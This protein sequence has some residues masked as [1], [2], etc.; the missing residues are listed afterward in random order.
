MNKISFLT[1]VILLGGSLLFAQ[2]IP[3]SLR[4]CLQ[5]AVDENI[6]IKT[7]RLE[8]EKSLF[9][10]A[11]AIAALVP[12]I[13]IGANYQDN[14]SLPT[15]MLPGGIIGQPGTYIPVSMGVQYNTT[16]GATLNWVLY[17]Q[18]ALTAIQLTKKVTELNDLGIEKAGE[19]LAAEVSKL[20]F[21]TMATSQQKVLI[22]A[23]IDRIKRLQEITKVLMN[24]GMA[25][26]VDYDRVSINLENLYT[27]LSNVEAGLEQQHSMIK[28]ILNI[29]LDKTIVLTDKSETGLLQNFPGGMADFSNHIDIRLLEQQKEMNLLN[30][31]LIK[32]GY[33][34][35][36]MFTGQYVYQGMRQEFKNYF[37]S[38]PENKW[39]HFSYIGVSLSIPVFDG[40]DKRAKTLQVKTDYRK[41]ELLLTD[42]LEKFTVD[43]QNAV[44]NYNNHRVNVERQKQNIELAE[45]VY[46]E[47]ALKYREGLAGM[48]NLLQDEMSLSAA[49]SGYLT[50]LYNYKEAEIKIM[51]LNGDIKTLYK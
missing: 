13:N 9:R 46:D 4:E 3:L 38:S 49:Q 11:E 45:K 25:K 27:Q 26:Q 15:T 1:V 36:L 23:N 21:L 33:M 34:P 28:Y 16:A 29:P 43:F 17:N 37:N 35:S 31:K 48:T 51:S 5:M 32:S 14:F 47:T 8:R 39:Y 12:K 40:G 18:T 2:D 30:Q 6:N 19:E 41:T 42:K 7:A 44:N 22:E 50:A 10:K 20:Y 24:N